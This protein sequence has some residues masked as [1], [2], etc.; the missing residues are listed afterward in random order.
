MGFVG[1]STTAWQALKTRIHLVTETMRVSIWLR[2]IVS[3]E[4]EFFMRVEV[5]TLQH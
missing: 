1:P 5:L 4:V 3:D 2:T